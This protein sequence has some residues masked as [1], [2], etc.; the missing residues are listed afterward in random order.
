MNTAWVGV[1]DSVQSGEGLRRGQ[2]Y[3]AGCTYRRG[4]S[5]VPMSSIP[6]PPC[7][8][9]AGAW[10]C[11]SIIDASRPWVTAWRVSCEGRHLE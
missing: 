8:I 11:G 2:C 1:V 3:T 6:A 5:I 9:P 10:H 7:L 4:R